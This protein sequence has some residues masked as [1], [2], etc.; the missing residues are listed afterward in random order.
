MFQVNP[1]WVWVVVERGL[2]MLYG[3]YILAGAS[4]Q[5][6]HRCYMVVCM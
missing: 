2:H 1:L 6:V 4:K 3:E 5:V